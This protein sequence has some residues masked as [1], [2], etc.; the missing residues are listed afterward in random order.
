V[1]CRAQKIQGSVVKKDIK[2]ILIKRYLQPVVNPNDRL[3]LD[4]VFN[5]NPSQNEL[6]EFLTHWDIEREGA[7]KTMMLS[8]FMK[9]HPELSFTEYA[10]PRLEGLLRYYRFYNMRTLACFPGLG[11]A[12]NRAGIPI[13]VFKGLA[14]KLLR[15]EL[16]RVME[17]IDFIV[18]EEKY[19]EAIHIAENAG[20]EHK[21]EQDAEHAVDLIHFDKKC[22]IDIHKCPNL[23]YGPNISALLFDRARN[24]NAYSVDMLIPCNEDM[25]FVIL[26]NLLNNLIKKTSIKG[27]LYGLFDYKYLAAGKPGFNWDIV[28]DNAYRTRTTFDIRLALEIIEYLV[29]GIMPQ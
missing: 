29:P 15:P 21:L 24:I 16:S 1:L 8:Y 27:V 25:V 13:L 17:D 23:K 19:A 11:R 14:M 12:L 9:M 7:H 28:I 18:P 10:K 6:D 26:T 22:L 4:L 20:F 2:T 3:L 5:E